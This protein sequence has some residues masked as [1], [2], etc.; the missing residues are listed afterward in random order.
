MTSEQDDGFQ[1]RKLVSEEEARKKAEETL[2]FEIGNLPH[3]GETEETEAEY[4]FPLVTTMPRVIFDEH[5]ERPVDVKFMSENDVGEIRVDGVSG[6]VSHRSNVY[7]VERNI[8]QQR[9]KLEIAV[10][11]ALV[12]SSAS[13]FSR[14]PFP[15]HRF[16]PITDILSHLILEGPITS[17]E[18]EKMNASDEQ[19]YQDYIDTLQTVN[20]VRTRGDS[21]IADDIFIEIQ[22]EKDTHPEMLNAA[23]AHFF[24]VGADHIETIRGILGPYLVIAGYYYQKA[25]EVS[26]GYPSISEDEFN[27][28]IAQRYAGNDR[29]QKMFKLPRYLIQLEEVELIETDPNRDG[30]WKGKPEVKE[31]LLRQDQLLAPIA[32]TMA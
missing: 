24:E 31:N 28:R 18:L 25:L 4:V 2:A 17:E 32:D 9:H 8:R 7:K 22:A 5:R 21:I 6:D 10:E 13:K 3:L 11:K 26:D 15:E 14:L 19:K 1:D 23:L 27:E 30:S 20:L 29:V 12:R 16:T